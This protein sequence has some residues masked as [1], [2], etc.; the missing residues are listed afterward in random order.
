MKYEKIAN[1]SES[2][3]RRITGVKRSTLKKMVEILDL[4][5]NYIK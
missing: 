4:L 5:R 3:F 2:T 1:Y